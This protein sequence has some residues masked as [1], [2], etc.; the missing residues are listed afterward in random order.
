MAQKIAVG[1]DVG[2]YQVKV[3]VAAQD[4][5]EQR[6]KILGT[7]Y[8]HSRGIRHGYV[9]NRQDIAKMLQ[10]AITQ[11]EKASGVA[12]R[13]AHLSVGGIGLEE[14]R[15]RAEIIVSR[16]DNVVTELDLKN[17][18]EESERKISSRLVNRKVIHAIPLVHRL[19]GERLLGTP[20]G[21]KGTKLEIETLFVT[22]LEQHLHE[23]IAAVEEVGV[24]VVDVMASPIAGSFVTL[25]KAQKIAGV[26]LANIGAETISIAV[27]END[28]PISVKVFPMGSTDI[29]H[30]I[31][32]GL[33][34]SIEDAEQ[35]KCGALV[36]S[37][38]SKKQ[39]DTIIAHRVSAIFTLVEAHLKRLGKN[40]LLPAGVVIS[41]GG[42]GIATVEDI[43]RVVLKIPSKR[44]SLNVSD[45]SKIKNSTW[46]VAYGLCIWGL[47]NDTESSNLSTIKENASGV[48]NWIKQFLP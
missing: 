35:A 24:T 42:S 25:T 32:L 27:F 39:L 46:A 1:I 22:A 4:P 6:A 29:T 45:K 31:A 37:I 5:K 9:V 18:L 14:Y 41:G 8:A 38:T 36:N 34:I 28:I 12:V 21:M 17:V 20:L 23:L 16:A 26:V 30:D 3:V 33:K 13:K 15:S 19:D 2:T 43:A 40:A 48:F 7:G 47:T 10:I 11:A 44:A